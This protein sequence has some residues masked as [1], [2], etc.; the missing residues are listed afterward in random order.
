M[1]FFFFGNSADKA[2]WRGHWRKVGSADHPSLKGVQWRVK[3][4]S[5]MVISAEAFSKGLELLDSFENSST[6]D[7]REL[8]EKQL[9]EKESE[10]K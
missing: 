1:S 8:L 2:F 7:L 6:D 5:C 9:A 3:E 4:Q 10:V